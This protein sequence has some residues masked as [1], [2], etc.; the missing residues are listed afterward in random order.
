ML[1]EENIAKSRCFYIDGKPMNS[2]HYI[3][4][5]TYKNV[6]EKKKF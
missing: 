1:E 3:F 2:S 5:P 4:D 6:N